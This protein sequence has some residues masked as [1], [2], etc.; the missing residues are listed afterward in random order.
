MPEAGL[1]LPLGLPQLR[2]FERGNE[3]KSLADSFT[4]GKTGLK[5]VAMEDT[6]LNR[7]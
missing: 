7:V 6:V 2:M 5:I 1:F 3:G 4:Q